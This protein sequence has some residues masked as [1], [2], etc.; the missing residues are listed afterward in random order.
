MS[1]YR[2]RCLDGECIVDVGSGSGRRFVL[3]PGP[4]QKIANHS[5]TGFQW[6]YSG[7]GPAQL[8]LAVLLNYT[9]DPTLAL[10]RHQDFK[11]EVITRMPQGRSWE[12]TDAEIQLWLDG[13]AGDYFKSKFSLGYGSGSGYG[14]YSGYGYGSGCELIP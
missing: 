14:D 7:S 6:G 8:A 13:G 2:G 4:S 10:R 12:L 5:P 11:W 9:G 3:D 1:T